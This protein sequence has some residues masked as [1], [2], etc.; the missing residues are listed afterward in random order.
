MKNKSVVIVVLLIL[1]SGGFVA[2]Q[3]E[4]EMNAA[5]AQRFGSLIRVKPEYEERYIILHRHTFPGVLEAIHRANIRNYSIFLQNGLLFSYSEYI[6]KDLAS[7]MEINRAD[8]TSQEWWKLTDPMQ[9]PLPSR[10]EGEWW[11]AAD[12]VLYVESQKKIPQPQRLAFLARFRASAQDSCLKYYREIPTE[13]LLSIQQLPVQKVA[14]YQHHD[15]L[16]AYIEYSGVD[17]SADLNAV[18]QNQALFDWWKGAQTWHTLP[19]TSSSPIWQKME[20][21]FHTN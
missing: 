2:C 21:V 18:M 14:V 17:L 13:I 5:P 4:S 1:A 9:E 7:D 15:R 6:G 20:E 12:E 3:K 16:V 8:T 11:A 10:K 19:D